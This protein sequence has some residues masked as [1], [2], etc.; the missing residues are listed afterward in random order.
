MTADAVVSAVLLGFVLGLQHATDPDH[1]AVEWRERR[2]WL[3]V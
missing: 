1:L 2:P 3:G